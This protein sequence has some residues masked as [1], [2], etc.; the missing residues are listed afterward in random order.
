MEL[1][2]V[3]DPKSD[4]SNTV[5]V[6]PRSPAPAQS[7][8]PL[9]RGRLFHSLTLYENVNLLS[10]TALTSILYSLHSG[11]PLPLKGA[12]VLFIN[13]IWACSSVGRAL[14]SQRRGR[15]FDPL[16]VHQRRAGAL[17][18]LA[19]VNSLTLYS[20]RTLLSL[21]VLTSCTHGR[22]GTAPLTAYN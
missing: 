14:R 12:L 6:R 20:R 21:V 8:C 2:D 11:E 16:Q 13:T 17:A 7:L 22:N 5:P 18:A 1:A 9:P 19:L 4:G 10:L 3:S 15:G